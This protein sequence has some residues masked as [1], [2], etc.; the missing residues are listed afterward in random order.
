[1]KNRF[2]SVLTVLMAA[3]LVSFL[4]VPVVTANEDIGSTFCP[5]PCPVPCPD[6][7]ADCITCDKADMTLAEI[8]ELLLM[9]KELLNNG[10]PCINDR[11]VCDRVEARK[12]L[13]QVISKIRK[14]KSQ[15]ALCGLL[16]IDITVDHGFHLFDPFCLYLDIDVDTQ[17]G[18]IKNGMLLKLAKNYTRYAIRASFGRT[19]ADAV[20]YIDV[21]LCQINTVLGALCDDIQLPVEP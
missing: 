12:L 14:A 5:G 4:F 21:A 17:E 2:F 6:P 7:G 16:G 11:E 3:L 18:V 1:M 20:A 10:D 19:D 13:F 9:A 8:Q 15:L